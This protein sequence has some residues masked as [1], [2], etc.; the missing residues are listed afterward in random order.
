MSDELTDLK[1]LL[2]LKRQDDQILQLA[3][4]LEVLQGQLDRVLHILEKIVG[5]KDDGK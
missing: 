4:N 5:A 1:M 2:R 3:R